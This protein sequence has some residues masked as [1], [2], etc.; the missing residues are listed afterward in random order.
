MRDLP[1]YGEGLFLWAITCKNWYLLMLIDPY[2]DNLELYNK[3]EG[4]RWGEKAE[5]K[6][7]LEKRNT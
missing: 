3:K 2:Y 6:S 4:I 7:K 5:K 1:F